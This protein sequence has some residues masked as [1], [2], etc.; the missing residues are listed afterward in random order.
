MPQSGFKQLEQKW[1]HFVW[2]AHSSAKIAFLLLLNPNW[3]FR[4]DV[5]ILFRCLK[6]LS[7]YEASTFKIGPY[8]SL[9]FS[10]RAT[11]QGCPALL[12]RGTT[13]G[14]VHCGLS[15]SCQKTEKQGFPV[16]WSATGSGEVWKDGRE[17]AHLTECQGSCLLRFYHVQTDYPWEKKENRRW[18]PWTIIMTCFFEYYS[19]E[20]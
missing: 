19:N 16:W 18:L 15:A 11:V 17:E 12:I 9:A 1:K 5:A 6:E 2:H 10:W 20:D 7:S 3:S 4:K 13:V 8:N 14:G